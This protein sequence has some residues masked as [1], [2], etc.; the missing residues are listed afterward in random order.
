MKE[1]TYIV[2][3]D[4]PGPIYVYEDDGKL[5]FRERL[6]VEITAQ[7]QKEAR[8][9][10]DSLYYGVWHEPWQCRAMHIKIERKETK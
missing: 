5:H 2:S 10:F 3:Y 1:R 7:N 9:K 8:K 6:F 4:Q